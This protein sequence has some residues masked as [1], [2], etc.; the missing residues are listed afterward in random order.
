MSD[1]HLTLRDLRELHRRSPAAIILKIRKSEGEVIFE[2]AGLRWVFI[3]D[4]FAGKRSASC[5]EVHDLT[6][7]RGNWIDRDSDEQAQDGQESVGF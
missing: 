1:A 6:D 5:F 7:S 2:D 3:V 4:T